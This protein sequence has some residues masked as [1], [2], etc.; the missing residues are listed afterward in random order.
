[1]LCSDDNAAVRRLPG[2]DGKKYDVW[3][4]DTWDW[5]H[6]VRMRDP[7]TGLLVDGLNATCGPSGAFWTYSQVRRGLRR[8]PHHKCQSGH[9]CSI[10]R[11][12]TPASASKCTATRKGPS[13]CPRR[14]AS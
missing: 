3:A 4:Q 7:V 8:R 6:A 11:A 1:M 13:S 10:A 9:C 5:L 12:S 14:R 2:A